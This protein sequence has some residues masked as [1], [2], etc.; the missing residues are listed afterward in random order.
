MR[1]VRHCQQGAEPSTLDMMRPRAPR[2]TQSQRSSRSPLPAS[3]SPG[4]TPASATQSSAGQD[5]HLTGSPAP[6][7]N[8]AARAPARHHHDRASTAGTAARLS[9]NGIGHRVSATAFEA[10]MTTAYLGQRQEGR[11]HQ[12]TVR[13]TVSSRPRPL[14][15]NITKSPASPVN[16]HHRGLLAARRRQRR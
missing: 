11:W 13:R 10:P 14:R 8:P 4:S 2:R 6:P 5:R 7:E 15:A 3:S 9:W 1:Q 16:G 12:P